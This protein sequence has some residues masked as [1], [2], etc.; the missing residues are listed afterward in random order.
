MLFVA[1]GLASCGAWESVVYNPTVD[2]LA[3]QINYKYGIYGWGYYDNFNRFY[4]PS[5]LIYGTPNYFGPRI[6]IRNNSNRNNTST[7]ATPRGSSTVN[8]TGGR[9][10]TGGGTVPR[11]NTGGRKNEQL[12][13][14]P[15]GAALFFKYCS[16]CH[17]NNIAGAPHPTEM[18]LDM[19]V[20]LN[21][22]NSMPSMKHLGEEKLEAIF[23]YINKLQNN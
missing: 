3:T 17:L 23:N 21:G 13:M 11:G 18:E 22:R 5:N 16:V 20:A 1:A 4:G 8:N 6:I 15:N 19:D 12:K 2:T 9:R 10:T 14:A 7:S